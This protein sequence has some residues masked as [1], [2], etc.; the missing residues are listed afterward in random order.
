MKYHFCYPDEVQ[1][2]LPRSLYWDLMNWVRHKPRVRKF[3]VTK[4]LKMRY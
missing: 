1:A 3:I 4:H 2:A